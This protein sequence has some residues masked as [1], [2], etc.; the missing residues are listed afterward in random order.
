MVS[1][2]VRFPFT[3]LASAFPLA[4]EHLLISES[5]PRCRC[6]F[7]Y[8]CRVFPTV[9][10]YDDGVV[11][12]VV[13]LSVVFGSEIKVAALTLS[14][15]CVA[16]CPRDSLCVCVCHSVCVFEVCEPDL[17]TLGF[18]FYFIF[19]SQVF[20]NFPPWVH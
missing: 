6:L 5:S 9:D 13:F 10:G 3:S 20:S 1:R 4:N 17:S 2:Q 19:F 18:F 14:L 16:V 12:L 11:V 7:P 15:E 8:V